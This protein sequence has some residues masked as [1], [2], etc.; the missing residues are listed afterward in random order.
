MKITGIKTTVLSIP[1][2]EGIQDAT[3]RHRSKGRTQ[4]FVHVITD[5][6]LEGLGTGGGAQAAREVI[7]R[8]LKP[9]LV[10]QNPLHIL[11]PKQARPGP[12]ARPG[13]GQAIRGL[14]HPFAFLTQ[15]VKNWR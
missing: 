5:E 10:G 7:E 3:I 14:A 8:T 13:G 6:G 11:R 9:V 12:D 15:G 4:C 2:L 1:H